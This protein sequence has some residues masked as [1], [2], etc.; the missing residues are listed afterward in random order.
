MLDY[1][2]DDQVFKSWQRLGIFLFTAVSRLALGPTQPHI[3][4]VPRA[5]SLGVKQLGHEADHSPPS[6]AK[7]KMHGVVPPLPDMLLWHH[8][9]LKAEGQLYLYFYYILACPL[10]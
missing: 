2:L 7:V 10:P 8:A 5:L 6:S 4:W 9:Q 3:Q 1:G